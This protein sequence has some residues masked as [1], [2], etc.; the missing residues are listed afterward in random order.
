[1]DV[2]MECT[3]AS[4][5]VGQSI[6]T[7]CDLYYCTCAHPLAHGLFLPTL[8]S[9]CRTFQV[10]SPISALLLV[11]LQSIGCDHEP[12]GCKFCGKKKKERNWL[13]Y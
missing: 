11:L 5:E 13:Q 12:L 2:V 1:M 3:I 4:L 7:S 6:A 9:F 8:L 10:L